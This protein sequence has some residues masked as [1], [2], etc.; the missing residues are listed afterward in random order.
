MNVIKKAMAKILV[1][2]ILENFDSLENLSQIRL[3]EDFKILYGLQNLLDLQTN[4]ASNFDDPE[5]VELDAD[6]DLVI[7][8]WNEFCESINKLNNEYESLVNYIKKLFQVECDDN[9]IISGTLLEHDKYI[10]REIGGEWKTSYNEYTGK[11]DWIVM[12]F[13]IKILSYNSACHMDYFF[14]D[15][16]IINQE[17]INFESID[18]KG[19]TVYLDNNSIGRIAYD[20]RFLELAKANNFNFIYSSYTIEDAIN[21]S[22]IY[23]KSFI[24]NLMF[25]TDGKMVGYT[26]N[27][28]EFV[29]ENIDKTISRVNKYNKL[30]RNAESSHVISIIRNYY[31]YPALRKGNELSNK[32]IKEGLIEVM[33]SDENEKIDGFNAVKWS[34]IELFPLKRLKEKKSK[35]SYNITE[36]NKLLDLVNYKTESVRFDNFQK[37]ASS[38]RDREHIN[39][40]YICD[41]FVTDDDR[42]ISRAS[43]IFDILGCKTVVLKVK[44]FMEI[45]NKDCVATI[46]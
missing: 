43:V 24:E 23:L 32:I 34:F 39:H 35:I 41:Y 5:K 12:E 3:S 8:A 16:G 11:M 18:I 45:C 1:N 25:I 37:I 30:T 6:Y 29:K 7:P 10:S 26:N 27:G 31:Q 2:K 33:D 38:H 44:K 21:S 22:P 28:I 40:A 20:K 36:L 19:K 14:D 46:K 15:C 42:L 17:N 4:S 9:F 13:K